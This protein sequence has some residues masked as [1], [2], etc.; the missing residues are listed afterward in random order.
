MALKKSN[1]NVITHNRVDKLFSET[2]K[3]EE[4]EKKKFN[5]FFNRTIF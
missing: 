4:K 3:R 5:Y 2:T 1:S